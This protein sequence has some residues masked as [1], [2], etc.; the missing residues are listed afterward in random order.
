MPLCNI[1]GVKIHTSHY[2]FCFF[3]SSITPCRAAGPHELSGDMGRIYEL[4][5]RHCIASVSHDA[6]WRSTKIS[7][8]I[9]ALGPK[10]KFFVSGK[11]IVSLGFL[12]VLLHKQYGDDADKDEDDEEEEAEPFRPSPAVAS[13]EKLTEVNSPTVD[14]YMKPTHQFKQ[15]RFGIPSIEATKRGCNSQRCDARR[16]KQ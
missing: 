4:V 14:P 13:G 9:E 6:V 7:F 8:E 2:L 15:L 16:A 12:E 5:V 10:G 3:L 11:E 1:V